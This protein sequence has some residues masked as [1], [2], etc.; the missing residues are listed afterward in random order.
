MERQNHSLGWFLGKTH[1]VA[2]YIAL[3]YSHFK[4]E[5]H[6]LGRLVTTPISGLS[7][8]FRLLFA[9]LRKG[10]YVGCWKIEEGT[11]YIYVIVIYL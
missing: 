2:M 8:R 10:C 11:K 4:W 7:S 5:P 1:N 9:P 3:Q 6:L